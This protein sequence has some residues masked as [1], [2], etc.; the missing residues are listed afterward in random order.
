MPTK[1]LTKV[2][3]IQKTVMASVPR[4]NILCLYFVLWL[5]RKDEQIIYGN[6]QTD[7]Q[8]KLKYD[9]TVVK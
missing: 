5:W 9:Q 3:I 2:W 1:F 8:Q 6:I 4:W 7:F